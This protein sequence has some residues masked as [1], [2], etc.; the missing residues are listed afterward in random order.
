MDIAGKVTIAVF[1]D[2]S[3]SF[4]DQPS[5]P[6]TSVRTRGG[7]QTVTKIQTSNNIKSK[8]S[9]KKKTG[10][11]SQGNLK[12]IAFLCIV[13]GLGYYFYLNYGVE[14]PSENVAVL[15]DSRPDLAPQVSVDS[16]ELKSQLANNSCMEFGELCT[17][18][19]L[20]NPQEKLVTTAERLIIF[21]NTAAQLTSLNSTYMNEFSPQ[22]QREY[23]LGSFAFHPKVVSAAKGNSFKNIV[24]VAIDVLDGLVQVKTSLV[25]DVSQMPALDQ[26]NY[27]RLFSNLF[28]GGFHR[29]YKSAFQPY[30]KLT[31][32]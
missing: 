12:I 1:A 7:D 30:T 3:E 10:R 22:D 27:D 4:Q 23:I 24:A 29:P 28:F 32:Y 21:V 26:E 15:T 17:E 18:L 6:A 2:D 8:T 13:I 16:T 19:K 31:H 9:S 25:V 5:S 20:T 11:A 14:A